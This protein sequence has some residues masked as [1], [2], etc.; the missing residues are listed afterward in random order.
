[1]VGPTGHPPLNQSTSIKK[2]STD[3]PLIDIYSSNNL[4]MIVGSVQ[5]VYAFG[6]CFK[7]DC[8]KLISVKIVQYSFVNRLPQCAF[9][10]HRKIGFFKCIE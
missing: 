3:Q 4:I 2:T 10:F 1:M 6:M 9:Q 8:L 5:C 7:V